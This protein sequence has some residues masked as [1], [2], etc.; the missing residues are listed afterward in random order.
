M[1]SKVWKFPAPLG[2]PHFPPA[3]FQI[4]LNDNLVFK[5][6]VFCDINVDYRSIFMKH[7]L[8]AVRKEADCITVVLGTN[9]TNATIF[10]CAFSIFITLLIWFSSASE[11][12]N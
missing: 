9:P 5:K 12:L 1:M 6:G 11:S 7:C 3:F 2:K 10:G 8:I 4:H